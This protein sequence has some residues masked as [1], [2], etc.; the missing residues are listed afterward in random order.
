MKHQTS[1]PASQNHKST[2]PKS[3]RMANH[4]YVENTNCEN[5]ARL[6]SDGCERDDKGFDLA[7]VPIAS[8]MRTYGERKLSNCARWP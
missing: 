1:Q 4:S 6:I 2:H 5:C 7:C 3:E 8:L